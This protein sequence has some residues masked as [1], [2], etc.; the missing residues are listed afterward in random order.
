VLSKST[1][2]RI[3]GILFLVIIPVSLATAIL[4]SGIDTRVEYFRGSLQTVADNETQNVVGS[5]FGFLMAG[6]FVSTGAALY[7]TFRSYDRL[8]SLIGAF[9]FLAAGV[10]FMVSMAAGLAFIELASEF[11]DVRGVQADQ[12][13]PAAR[14]MA[15]VSD[16]TLFAGF[17]FFGLG[18]LALGILI[19]W[20]RPLPRWLGW[21]AA[22]SGVLM[23]L[24]APTFFLLILGLLLG[25]VWLLVAGAWLA[26]RGTNDAAATA[27]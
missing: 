2:E 26:W 1:I 3:T 22:L 25:L 23:V 21:L 5:V 15:I 27:G 9:G 11:G 7:V 6:L 24:G 12:I 10:S 19:I 20:R 14:S 17:G 4:D 18:L 8:L 16:W 13:V